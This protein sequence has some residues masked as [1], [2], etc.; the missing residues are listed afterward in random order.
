MKK[1]RR[2]RSRDRRRA[3]FELAVAHDLFVHHFGSRTFAGDRID[4][5]GLQ[6]KNAR[7][8]AAKWG[9]NGTYGR[10]VAL[11]PVTANPPIDQHKNVG[12]Q[13]TQ[14]NADSDLDSAIPGNPATQSKSTINS[15]SASSDVPPARSPNS[16]L[17][18]SA[19]SADKSPPPGISE[20]GGADRTARVSL[21]MITRDEKNLPKCLE[22]VRGSFDEIVVIDTGSHD[23]TA[24][25]ARSF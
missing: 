6:D 22:S 11:T 19:K 1:T 7:R 8:F 2:S 18:K 23:R 24:E 12:P 17:R 4:A 10:R 16:Y 3:G 13:I 25:I 14:I 15:R 20:T 5:E 21:T 9:L